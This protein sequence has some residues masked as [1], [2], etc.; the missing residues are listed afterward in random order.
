MDISPKTGDW[1]TIPIAAAG[2]GVRARRIAGLFF[3]KPKGK[4]FALLGRRTGTGKGDV[5]WVYLLVHHVHQKQD[6]SLLPPDEDYRIAAKIG[7]ES[8]IAYLQ[9]RGTGG[10]N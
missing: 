4:N 1:L 9:Q 5:Q 7:A 3:V 8:Y 10:S 2:Y 6:R